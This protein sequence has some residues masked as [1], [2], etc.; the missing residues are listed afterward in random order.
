MSPWQKT[1]MEKKR[2]IH[3]QIPK[4][5]LLSR[6]I[7]EK[8][9]QQKQLSGAFIESLLDDATKSITSLISQELLESMAS[10]SLT[11]VQVTQAFCRRSAVA[12]Q[13]V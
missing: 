13:I 3:D 10:G 7:L 2:Q 4:D 12:H 9:Q 6:S 11:A 5:W 1:A 8:A